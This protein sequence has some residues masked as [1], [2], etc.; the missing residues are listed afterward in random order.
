MGRTLVI[1]VGNRYRSDDAAGLVVIDELKSRLPDS[2]E[3]V[4]QSGDAAAL[5]ESWS[6]AER[7]FVIDAVFSNAAAG[8][9]LRYDANSGRV[10][11]A[12][13]R[14]STHMF[15]IAEAVEMARSLGE[16]PSQLII[17]GIEGESFATGTGVSPRV[18]E[19][20]HK[21]VEL[22]IRETADK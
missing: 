6:G 8:T 16:L 1:G 18:K 5:I 7:V 9:I 13:F 3:I 11:C 15:G 4:E 22:L 2:V 21:I 17:Y 12:R 14:C 19:A 20:S 10:P